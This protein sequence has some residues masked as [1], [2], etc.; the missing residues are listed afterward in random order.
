MHA[1]RWSEDTCII[2]AVEDQD[3]NHTCL[4]QINDTCIMDA[5]GQGSWGP[6]VGGSGVLW[7][8]AGGLEVGAQQ[9]LRLLVFDILHIYDISI[10]ENQ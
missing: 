5:W 4:H 3:V 7:V 6:G 1:S 10:V 2:H 9:A 8:R